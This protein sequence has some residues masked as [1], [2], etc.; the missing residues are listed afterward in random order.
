MKAKTSSENIVV[1]NSRKVSGSGAARRLRSE[2]IL[3]GII[4]DN[5]EGSKKIQF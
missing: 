4:N 3:P 5:K 2:G 1:A